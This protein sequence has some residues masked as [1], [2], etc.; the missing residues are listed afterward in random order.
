MEAVGE[1]PNIAARLQAFAAPNTLLVSG[2]TQRL[3][4]GV[5]D[6]QDIGTQ[7]LKGV[8]KALQVYRVVS[9][10]QRTSRFEAAHASSLTP[11]IGRSAELAL[12]LDRWGK[13]KEGDG[14]IVLLSGLP[15]VGK[16]R[17]IH[18]LKSSIQNEP[19][20]LLN[21]QCSPYHTQSA[22]LPIIEQIELAA[23]LK[24][25]DSDADKF[26]KV[27]DYLA[28][29]IGV[30]IE[31]ASL[32]AHLL[33]ISLG[34]WNI[35]STLTPPQIK[36]KTVDT[37]LEII[38]SLSAKQATLCMFEDVHW[39]DPST[40]ELLELAMSWVDRA[41]VMIVVSFRPEFRH[42]W[43]GRANATSHSLSRLSRS[44]VT[45]MIREMSR[46][47]DLPQK[48]LDQIAEK[49]DGVPLFIEELTASTIMAPVENNHQK[50]DLERSTLI[51]PAKVPETLHD[52]L[53]E[54]VD[55]VVHGRRLAQVAAVI[56][57]EF[58]YDLLTAASR[59]DE[60]KSAGDS[61][62]T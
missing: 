5:F 1:T 28:N 39:I 12:L 15:G 58:S 3:A 49:A 46:D 11:L 30:R 62:T 18:E 60:L 8:T 19:H 56:G 43:S 34:D 35:L 16:S 29:V 36:N 31:S 32:I 41:H 48:I 9:A 24:G 47:E 23:Q 7:E 42:V 40:L 2:S 55:R 27:K 20:S 44:E 21:Y 33:S 54:R 13:T 57:R 51:G 22:Y 38:L 61:V 59:T 25:A 45:K 17:L 10:K 50:S 37:L 52:A 14:Q 6:F 4:S 26:A 53:M